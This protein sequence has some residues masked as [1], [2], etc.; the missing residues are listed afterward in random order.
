[1]ASRPQDLDAN[2]LAEREA[3]A[4]EFKP[5]LATAPKR[6]SRDAKPHE[7][8]HRDKKQN[9]RSNT[10]LSCP[11]CRGCLLTLSVPS[12]SLPSRLSLPILCNFLFVSQE[13]ASPGKI[14]LAEALNIGDD[15]DDE[16]GARA[17]VPLDLLISSI[18]LPASETSWH[19]QPTP[20]SLLLSL[21]F[22]AL[23]ETRLSPSSLTRSLLWSPFF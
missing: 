2:A 6:R 18:V 3:A 5:K 20:S 14:L 10:A 21:L 12:C 7:V 11:T 19:F 4:L 13:P 9:T 1:M 17:R 8:I 22:W 16:D 23:D 15:D